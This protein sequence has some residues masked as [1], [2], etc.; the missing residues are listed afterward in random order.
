[1]YITQTPYSY[2]AA[3]FKGLEKQAKILK[4]PVL[5]GNAGRIGNSVRRANSPVTNFI[6]VCIPTVSGAAMALGGVIPTLDNNHLYSILIPPK[7]VSVENI[8]LRLKDGTTKDEIMQ[9]LQNA[10]E[11]EKYKEIIEFIPDPKAGGEAAQGNN[12]IILSNMLF[13]GR[14]LMIRAYYDKKFISE[15][16]LN[17]A[18]KL[19]HEL[20]AEYETP[21]AE[22]PI[23]EK[24]AEQISDYYKQ[25][26]TSMDVLYGGKDANKIRA[27]LKEQFDLSTQG[28]KDAM[29]PFLTDMT[30]KGF[31][32]YLSQPEE[33]YRLLF[34]LL[35]LSDEGA[36]MNL[37]E[38]EKLD[39]AYEQIKKQDEGNIERELFAAML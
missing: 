17:D 22:A 7:N 23:A 31:A 4:N 2:N 25:I 15:N 10:A 20:M 19:V 35:Y 24:P 16:S 27:M 6:N 28:K 18:L 33:F 37:A 8:A 38:R 3:N 39:Q 9:V 26:E 30:T 11:N 21:I 14:S 32:T 1:M 13:P 5:A 29:L 34:K 12:K 36:Y